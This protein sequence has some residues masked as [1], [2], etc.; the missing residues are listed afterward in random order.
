MVGLI[1]ESQSVSRELDAAWAGHIESFNN[2][3]NQNAFYYRLTK[4]GQYSAIQD[5]LNRYL[6]KQAPSQAQI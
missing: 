3:I 2:F 6:R 5:G 1:V 4:P